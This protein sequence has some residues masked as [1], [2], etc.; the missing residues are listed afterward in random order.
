MTVFKREIEMIKDKKFAD[1]TKAKAIDLSILPMRGIITADIKG[2]MMTRTGRLSVKVILP[3]EERRWKIK[4]WNFLS[5]PVC[6]S[7][8]S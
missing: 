2:I 6:R 1:M 3:S 5:N 8:H 7:L 4:I